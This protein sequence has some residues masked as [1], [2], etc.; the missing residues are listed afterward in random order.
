MTTLK[1]NDNVETKD[2]IP[3]LTKFMESIDI[4][5]DS[6]LTRIEPIEFW[7]RDGFHA[8][9]RNRGGM[10]LIAFTDNASLIGCGYHIGTSIE[11]YVEESFNNTQDSIRA[12]NPDYTDD[13]VFD[14]TYNSESDDYSGQA[15]RVR[16]IY[17]GNNTL[18]VCAG[19]D[20]DAPYYGW[21]NKSELEKVIKFKN[22]RDLKTKLNK[23][24][25]K[26]EELS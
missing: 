19:W 20:K 6:H 9:D 4:G 11:S 7:S 13:Q 25:K 5:F 17:E 3:L 8:F 18:V 24:L 22:K 26:I 12:E 2:L 1:E 16:I 15:F 23:L 10:N 21:S 14:E